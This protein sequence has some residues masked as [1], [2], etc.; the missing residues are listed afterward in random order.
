MSV[1]DHKANVLT[2]CDLNFLI[3]NKSVYC[4]IIYFTVDVAGQVTQIL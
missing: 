4:G 2:N 1:Q 3:I